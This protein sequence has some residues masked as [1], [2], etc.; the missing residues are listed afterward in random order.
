[1]VFCRKTQSLQSCASEKESS[2]QV[3]LH[4]LS[5]IWVLRGIYFC[6]LLGC[7]VYSLPKLILLENDQLLHTCFILSV[8]VVFY[9]FLQ[10]NKLQVYRLSI[11]SYRLRN[12]QDCSVIKILVVKY[13]TDSSF[14]ELG[15][16]NVTQV[17]V[18]QS[19]QISVY[20]SKEQWKRN[21]H[22]IKGQCVYLK[23]GDKFC[24]SQRI[25]AT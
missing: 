15:H 3:H 25:L 13:V 9:G 2:S 8:F 24:P 4:L 18:Q 17:R 23:W 21:T 20:R 19:D 12:S 16:C 1:M 7:A 14:P 5:E 11:D 6:F 10:R 22:I